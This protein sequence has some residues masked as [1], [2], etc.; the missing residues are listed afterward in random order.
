LMERCTSEW[1]AMRPWPPCLFERRGT[2]SDKVTHLKDA[3]FDEAVLKSDVPVLVDFW[4]PWCGP[5]HIIAPIVEQLADDYEG[6]VKVSK[7]NVDENPQTAAKYG[8]RSI[9]TLLVF[10]DGKVL[11]QVIG[12]V[13]KDELVRRLSGAL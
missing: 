4:A 11:D 1:A 13:S 2:M 7:L 6:K 9:P 8:I 3:E 5:C 12:A 10:K